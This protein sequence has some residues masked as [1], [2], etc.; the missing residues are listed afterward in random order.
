MGGLA[1]FRMLQQAVRPLGGAPGSAPA[2]SPGSVALLAAPLSSLP[3]PHAPSFPARLPPAAPC[4]PHSPGTS[5]PAW[6][7][8][9]S[10]Q[11]GRRWQGEEG[12]KLR[13][14]PALLAVRAQDQRRTSRHLL[15]WQRRGGPGAPQA[16]VHSPTLAPLR[17][18]LNSAV[19]ALTGSFQGLGGTDPAAGHGQGSGAMPR[20]PDP[21][22]CGSELP[23]PPVPGGGWTRSI[24]LVKEVDEEHCCSDRGGQGMLLSS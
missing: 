20:S 12:G 17:A 7:A 24:V 23:A 22:R 4:G 13:H 9:L 1:F 19:C 16:V 15:S 18:W 3:G 14:E 10:E 21:Q 8:H 2:R 6:P 11:G 5:I